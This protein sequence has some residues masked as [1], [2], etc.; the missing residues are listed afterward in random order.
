MESSATDC[1]PN[2]RQLIVTDVPLAFLD[3]GL[4]ERNNPQVQSNIARLT[5]SAAMPAEVLKKTTP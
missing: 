3:S 5:R 1:E 2:L 4:G